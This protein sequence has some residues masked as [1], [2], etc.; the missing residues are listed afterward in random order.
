MS[1][2]GL[3]LKEELKM[4]DPKYIIKMFLVDWLTWAE[5]GAEHE[6]LCG[7]VGLCANLD[8]WMDDKLVY[9]SNRKIFDAVSLTLEE[10]LEEDFGDS[11]Y[12]FGE[13]AYGE[14]YWAYTQHKN[15]DRLAWVEKQI[16]L[17]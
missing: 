5:S 14:D 4:T 12:P 7:G 16:S 11:V 2:L 13:K 17:L 10:M 8:S 15:K 6:I 3:F 1:N 9:Q